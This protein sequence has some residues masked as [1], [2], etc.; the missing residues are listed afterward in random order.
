MYIIYVF[1]A[2][3]P[4]ILNKIP[5]SMYKFTWIINLNVATKV[6]CVKEK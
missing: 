1:W 4:H 6:K 2:N 5:N 3:R